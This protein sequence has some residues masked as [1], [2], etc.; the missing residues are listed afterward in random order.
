MF[1]F[2]EYLSHFQISFYL[3]ES[4]YFSLIT[5]CSETITEPTSESYV[6]AP[7]SAVLTPELLTLRDI[8][9]YIDSEIE[10]GIEKA[11]LSKNY[12]SIEEYNS[13]KSA[14]IDTV[15][16]LA[17]AMK[18]IT[19]IETVIF[20]HDDEGEIIRGED[21]KPVLNAPEKPVTSEIPRTT[22]EHKATE[23]ALFLRNAVTTT[24][25]PFVSPTKIMHFLKEGLSEPLR[26]K[27]I[28]N[29]RQFKKDILDKAK[30]MFPFISLDKKKHG[31]RDVRVVYKPEY[32]SNSL[33]R[34]H[35]YIRLKPT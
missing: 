4:F 3:I 5:L 20:E 11:L 33:N 22:L 21:N 24:G 28:Q 15:E 26:M 6:F 16:L 32:D 35:P 25:Q 31:R 2:Y 10:K 9:A 29:P 14:Y 12:V 34:M 1:F 30:A 13:L 18:R 7:I 17:N 23:F 8:K 27:D 19:Q